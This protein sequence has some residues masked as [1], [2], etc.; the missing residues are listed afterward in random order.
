MG[1]PAAMQ[2]SGSRVLR[3][4]LLTVRSQDFPRT[5]ALSGLRLIVVVGLENMD[6]SVGRAYRAM[7]SATLRRTAL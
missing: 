3:L 5:I 2:V 4:S 7:H 6:S 1:P